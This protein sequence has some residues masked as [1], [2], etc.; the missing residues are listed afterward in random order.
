MKNQNIVIRPYN[1]A[2][3]IKKL[4]TIWLDASMI[5][6]P[7]IGEDRLL[8]QQQLIEKKYLPNAETLVACFAAKPVGFMSLMGSFVGGIFVAPRHQG[9]GVGR[10]LIANAMGQKGE[11]SLE[12]YKQNKQAVEFYKALGFQQVSCRPTDDDGLPFENALLYLGR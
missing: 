2:T 4:S 5:A 3:D 1:A 12:V 7:F 8:E 9:R 10:A 11:L 6:H